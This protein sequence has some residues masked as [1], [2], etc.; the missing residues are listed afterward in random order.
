[1]AEP[2]LDPRRVTRRSGSS[3]LPAFLFLSRERRRA[4]E[5]VYAFCRAVDDVA[6][7]GEEGEGDKGAALEKF[8]AEV[9][10]VFQGRPETPIGKALLEAVEFGVR[11]ED[12][13]EVIQGCRM[14]LV[15]REYRTFRELEVYCRK[16]ASAV[17]RMC[18]AVFGVV[19]PR[20]P[21]Y[22]DATGIALQLTNILRDVGEDFRRGRIYL[23]LEDL[24]RFGVERRLLEP[25]RARGEEERRALE[26][27]FRFEVD[28]AGE[29]YRR[30]DELLPREERR[31][32]LP[33][34]IMKAVY[35][36]LLD[37]IGRAGASLPDV[38]IHL[39]RGAKLRIAA[40]TWIRTLVGAGG[41]RR[42]GRGGG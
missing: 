22:A 9:D 32:L 26:G 27:L 12:L 16:V 35:R 33:G 29:F 24:E 42:E 1:M 23:P 19:S 14:D 11:R 21:A 25:G 37:R 28:R 18:I 15:R 5:G 4:L 7:A 31:K 10:R 38:R 2:E 40:G 30:S 6:D 34:E 17:G 13:E 8:Q 39:G 41:P 20:A 36:V 3:F